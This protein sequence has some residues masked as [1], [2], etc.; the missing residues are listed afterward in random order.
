MS[1]QTIEQPPAIKLKRTF[2]ATPE[3]V[4]AAWTKPEQMRRWFGSEKCRLNSIEMDFRIGGAYRYTTCS[5]Q[6]GEISVRG[7]FREITPPSKLVYTWQWEDDA[8][9]AEHASLIT[10]EFIDLGGATE[11]RLTHEQIPTAESC[12]NHEVG[13]TDSLA[14]LAKLLEA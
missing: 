2:A 14:K 4:F 10:V 1:I 11:L 7:E 8:D 12:A 9:W 13:W 5:E 6:H 3:R